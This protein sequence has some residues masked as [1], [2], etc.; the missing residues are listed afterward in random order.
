MC[1]SLDL[2]T[3]SIK[4]Y[5][6]K[7]RS[8]GETHN[9]LLFFDRTKSL[10]TIRINSSCLPKTRQFEI[11][12]DEFHAIYDDQLHRK[13][14]INRKLIKI[15][16]ELPLDRAVRAFIRSV[17]T[18]KTD[19]RFG[20]DLPFEIVKILESASSKVGLEQ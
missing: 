13:L 3:V 9:L 12:N 14:V 7:L 20:F 6:M 1:L 5:G 16:P 18:G 2:G 4:E 15:D 19:W 10:S 17:K 8:P 11:E